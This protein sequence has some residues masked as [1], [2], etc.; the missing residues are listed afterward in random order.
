LCSCAA[1]RSDRSTTSC[2]RSAISADRCSYRTSGADAPLASGLVP[3]TLLGGGAGGYAKVP[4]HHGGVAVA[5]VL[6][7][8]GVANLFCLP[9]GH[10]GAVTDGC[11]KHGIRLIGTRHEAAAVHMAEAWA[12][13]TGQ[14]G[15]AGVTAGPGF[16]NSVTGLANSQA[17]GIPVVVL[18]GRTPWGLRGKGAVPAVDPEALGRAAAQW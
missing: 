15:V 6:R 9:G 11:A 3:D 1:I 8:A 12:R 4:E 2:D 16:T 14:T 13:C 5:E 17:G 7:A 10:L 18:G